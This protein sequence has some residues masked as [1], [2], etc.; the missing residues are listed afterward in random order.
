MG[1]TS[2]GFTPK[3]LAEIRSDISDNIKLKLGADI[4]TT[5]S[6]RIGQF[7]DIVS[8]EIYSAWLGLQD[9]YNSF[10]PDTASGASLDNVVAITNTARKA[11]SSSVGYVYFA[12]T[13]STIIPSGSL[14][15]KTGTEERLATIED[16]TISDKAN[17]II[18]N[19]VATSGT[20][21]LAWDSVSIAAINWND[22]IATIKAA[23]EAHSGISNVTVTGGFNTVG[24]VH[25]VFVTDTLTSRAPTIA[26]NTLLR[27]AAALTAS[28]YFST[29][30]PEQVVA[31]NTGAIALSALSVRTITTPL[32]G[33]SDILNFDPGTEGADRETDAQLRSRR[34]LELQKSG[35]TTIGGMRE[36]IEAIADVLNVTIIENPTSS[37]DADGRPAHSVEVFVTGG[38]DN[39][40]AQAIYDSKPIGI[41]IVTTVPGADQRSGTIT[42]VNEVSQT[43]IFSKPESIAISL[44]VNIT[45]SAATEGTVYPTDGD[46]QVKDA[47]IA[48]FKTLILGNDVKNHN[49]ITPVNTVPGIETLTILQGLKTAGTP[50]GSANIAISIKQVAVIALSTDITVNS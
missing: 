3:S 35:T 30:K 38:L 21:T 32:L 17:I 46:Q 4:D 23:I 48:Y 47:L 34:T 22:S 6:S 13:A 15:Q 49:L 28:A 19:D 42:D 36:A 50:T 29:E 18:C 16:H 24:A 10:Y 39:T 40:V 14:V 31:V 12:G 11:A 7:I 33:L 41:G 45:K 27:S 25:I 37:T 26:A 2:A 43:L 20:I 5:P 44:I 1:L 8:N 9:T